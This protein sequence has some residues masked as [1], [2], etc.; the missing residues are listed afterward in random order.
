MD[1]TGKRNPLGL[2]DYRPAEAFTPNPA[3]RA[4]THLVALGLFAAVLIVS[5][6]ITYSIRLTKDKPL[7][8]IIDLVDLTGNTQDKDR[9]QQKED[10]KVKEPEPDP[11]QEPPK[12]PV[13]DTPVVARAV[14]ERPPAPV[15]ADVPSDNNSSRLPIIAVEGAGP[16]RGGA[17][18]LA[19]RHD[20]KAA[21]GKYG[22]DGRTE[23]AVRL[24]L[25]W[26]ARHQSPDGSWGETDFAERC[27][28]G[29]PCHGESISSSPLNPAVTGLALLAFCASDSTHL[30]GEHKDQV[31]KGVK[32]LLS[33]QAANGQFGAFRRD[34][35]YHMM[36][37]QG[38][39]TFALGEICAMSDDPALKPPLEKAVQ[40]ICN[41]QQISGSWDYTDAKTGRYDTSVT[42]WQVMA[43]KSA[44]AAGIDVPARTIFKT[45][46]FIDGVTLPSGEVFYSNQ[47]PGIGRRG[48]GIA[49]VGMAS[50]QFLG[51]PVDS[52]LAKRQAAIFLANPPEWSRV[53]LKTGMDSIY[54]WYY[55]TIALFQ[56]GGQPWDQWN[57]ELKKTVLL[58]QRR[59]GCLDGSWDPP[60]N[61]WDR[62]GGR[63]YATALNV[64]NMEIYYR[65]LPI[66]SGASLN[67]VDALI[68]VASDAKTD[69]IQAVRLLGKFDDPKARDFL[70]GLANGESGQLSVE[71]ACAL[72]E[73]RLPASVEPLRRQLG[74][75]NQ[76]V[77]YRSLRALAPMI[78]D[79]LAPVFIE[80]L[81]DPSPT[82]ARFADQMLRQ[83]ANASFGFETEAPQTERDAAI[84]RWRDWWAGQQKGIKT[85][86]GA[87]LWL[88]VSVRTDKGLVAFSTG[89]PGQTE[90]GRKC[91][92]YRN[93]RFIGRIDV[94]KV[95][96]VITFGKILDQF[97]TG[98]IKE[99]DVVR[100]GT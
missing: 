64:L 88:V 56:M 71:A 41:A 57:K 48:Q 78:G 61:W 73:R 23:D 83:Y 96:G 63:V 79:G 93:D 10:P 16:A 26:L 24:G 80:S 50:A 34:L 17:G 3:R 25:Q 54:Y 29:D 22:G 40:F 9:G 85:A 28:P 59:G 43:L 33:I 97:T 91:N 86:E 44:Q 49:A 46:S 72:A 87:P 100:P 32:Y 14:D 69:S 2:A 7:P 92:V 62:M 35:N 82:V 70:L 39:A 55:A 74:S 11:A 58:R 37:N 18:I 99:G 90:E 67:T 95:D 6:A 77:R 51:F 38:I 21:L 53:E 8:T 81:R 4:A 1:K 76:F 13:P 12:E 75:P 52:P 30:K 5:D 47:T 27:K 15:V 45:A 89:K 20:K 66:Y 31:A 98:E 19:G 42:G 36:Y 65:Y 60:A 68:T 94:V 84:Q